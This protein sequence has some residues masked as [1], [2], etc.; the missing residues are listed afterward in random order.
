[1]HVCMCARV[2]TCARM[3]PE[4][5]TLMGL[6][7]AFNYYDDSLPGTFKNSQ[8]Y[9]LQFLPLVQTVGRGQGMARI[10]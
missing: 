2:C 3:L 6:T 9:H 4:T 1:M 5:E 7:D 10:M 8:M